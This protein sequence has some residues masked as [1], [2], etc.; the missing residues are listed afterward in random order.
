MKPQAP[1]FHDE[2]DT[3]S[4]D[5]QEVERASEDD[6]WFLPGPMGDEPDYLLPGPRA[7]PRETEVLD[8][9]RKAEGGQPRVLLEW[10]VASARWTTG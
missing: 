2:S 5:G 6:L 7:E 8:D 4:L 9:W 3:F 10:P 1:A